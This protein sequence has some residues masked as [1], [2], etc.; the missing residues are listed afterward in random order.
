VLQ[1]PEQRTEGELRRVLRI[2]VRQLERAD[3]Y[4]GAVAAMELGDEDAEEA[5]D[6][7]RDNVETLCQYLLA[8]RAEA[9]A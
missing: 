4:L 9:G 1:I 5:I 7:L 8:L 2:A 6:R 3:L